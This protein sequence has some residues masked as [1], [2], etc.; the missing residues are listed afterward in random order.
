MR[1]EKRVH[2]DNGTL[3]TEASRS[4]KLCGDLAGHRHPGSTSSERN[5]CMMPAVRA[6][7]S[8]LSFPSLTLVGVSLIF[9]V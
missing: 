5:R 7:E 3:Y 1:E 4:V 8:I 9:Y 6:R 2:F